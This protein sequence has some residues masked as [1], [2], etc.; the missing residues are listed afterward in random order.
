MN[1]IVK[2]K[3]T[4]IN[5]WI[6]DT[7]LNSANFSVDYYRKEKFVKIAFDEYTSYYATTIQR[8]EIYYPILSSYEKISGISATLTP[9]SMWDRYNKS[10]YIMAGGYTIPAIH[11]LKLYLKD[12]GIHT[13]IIKSRKPAIGPSE[14]SRDLYRIYPKTDVDYAMLVLYL[15]DDITEEPV[16]QPIQWTKGYLLPV[17]VKFKIQKKKIQKR[18]K[19]NDKT[20]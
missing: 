16:N 19:K 8:K 3:N 17:S 10:K 15:S 6:R 4:R 20:K 5:N 12:I 1:N 7:W 11:G 2:I 9:W 13:R 14:F 18:K